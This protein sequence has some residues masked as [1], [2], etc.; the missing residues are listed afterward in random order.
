MTNI[1]RHRF[2]LQI[3]FGIAAFLL[4]AITLIWNDWIEMVFNI[5]PDQ[6]SGFVE[7]SIMGIALAV[8]VGLFMLAYYEWR[9]THT[10][11]A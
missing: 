10:V 6:N 1:L 8:A 7:W 5:D 9:V 3:G 11:T 2:Y 4:F